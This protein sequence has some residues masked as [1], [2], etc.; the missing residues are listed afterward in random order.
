MLN[1]P[2]DV[3]VPMNSRSVG[4]ISNEFVVGSKK[5]NLKMYREAYLC[6]LVH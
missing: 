1:S 3:E 2:E 4:K 5:L 6:N